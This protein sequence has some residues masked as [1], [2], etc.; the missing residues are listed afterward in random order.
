MMGNSGNSRTV[1]STE[2]N[3]HKVWKVN[4]SF[5]RRSGF[6]H[7]ISLDLYC[8]YSKSSLSTSIE[9][10]HHLLWIMQQRSHWQYDEVHCLTITETIYW[11]TC[12]WTTFPD[13]WES[14]FSNIFFDCWESLLLNGIFF[15]SKRW[16]H[17]DGFFCYLK[18]WFF[19]HPFFETVF[20]VR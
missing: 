19:H 11:I 12:L 3:S 8:L 15:S 5:L 10:F 6:W 17:F 9:L 1:Q 14:L 4:W 18:T 16:L 2:L 20:F 13:R 7:L